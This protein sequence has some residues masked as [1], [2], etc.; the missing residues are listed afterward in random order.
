M[1]CCWSSQSLQTLILRRICCVCPPHVD[2]GKLKL[3]KTGGLAKALSIARVAERLNLDLRV[4]CYSD[5]SLLNGAPSQLTSLILWPDLD[6]H[7]NFMDDSYLELARDE[8]RLSP[9]FAT[10]LGISCKSK[11][12]S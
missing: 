9:P 11:G 7:L 5:S 4:G 10:G 3:L 6:S 1:L 12:S 8:D 2:G